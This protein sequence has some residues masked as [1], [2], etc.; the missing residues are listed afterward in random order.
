MGGESRRGKVE[1]WRRVISGDEGK[2]IIGY[3]THLV[4]Q[5]LFDLL[6]DLVKSAT[7]FLF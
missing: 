7:I 6:G 5:P 4:V 3:S 1:G 2:K